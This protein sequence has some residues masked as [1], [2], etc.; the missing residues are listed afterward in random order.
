ML[1]ISFNGRDKMA[2]PPPSCRQDL[3]IIRRPYRHYCI[4]LNVPITMIIMSFLQLWKTYFVT[5]NLWYNGA[6]ACIS[7]KKETQ[8][9]HE[10]YCV[11]FTFYCQ[12]DLCREC[13][14]FQINVVKV[15]IDIVIMRAPTAPPQ[16]KLI[17]DTSLPRKQN[18]LLG[19]MSCRILNNSFYRLC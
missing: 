12:M 18:F 8:L 7:K 10:T 17:A 6:I 15:K 9:Y 16:L 3:Y 4:D 11:R 14:Y 13:I 19:N 5:T 1:F 2:P